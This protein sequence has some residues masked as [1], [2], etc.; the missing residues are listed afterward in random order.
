M[1]AKH[2]MSPN[3]KRAIRLTAISILGVITLAT[4]WF[5]PGSHTEVDLSPKSDEGVPRSALATVPIYLQT[6]P[7]WAAEKVG[8]SGEALQSVGCTICC[9]SMALAHHGIALDP[10]ELNQKLKEDNGYTF[11]GWVKWDALQR[12]SGGRVLVEL[13]KTP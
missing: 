11:R 12:V 3:I 1:L 9:L 7:K 8:G 5:L 10:L 6:D 4:W 13:L 2:S